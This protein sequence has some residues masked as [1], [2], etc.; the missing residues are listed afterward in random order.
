MAILLGLSFPFR[1]HFDNAADELGAI[2][3]GEVLRVGGLL[4]HLSSEHSRAANPKIDNVQACLRESVDVD[5]PPR[6]SA[7][8]CCA[9]SIRLLRGG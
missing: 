6:R 1:E 5:A 4:A 3:A 9:Q 8:G 2:G 7:R